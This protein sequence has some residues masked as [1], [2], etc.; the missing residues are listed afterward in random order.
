[1]EAALV[2]IVPG[3]AALAGLVGSLVQSRLYRV[4][5]GGI[6][7]RLSEAGRQAS[8][9]VN[10][11]IG[12]VAGDL[13]S[14]D[15]R[16]TIVAELLETLEA[17][18]ASESS[19]MSSEEVESLIEQRLSALRDRLVQIET[20]FP[21]EATFDKLAS[22]NEAILATRLDAIQDNIKQLQETLK[23]VP[24][25]WDIAVIVFAIL[26]ALGVLTGM[27]F[28]VVKVSGH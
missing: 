1:M 14:A 15:T 21:S 16:K 19:A 4:R 26:S 7:I 25:N 28:A 2:F 17:A 20:R 9:A 5:I 18:A 11:E 23:K 6:E 27:L 22:V 10:A 24:S 13:M 12:R 3:L 8:E